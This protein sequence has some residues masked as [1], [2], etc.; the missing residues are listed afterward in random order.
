QPAH[1]AM[2]LVCTD[3]S[4]SEL[5]LVQP[6]LEKPRG[7]PAADLRLA[8]V[9]CIECAEA[10]ESPLVNA[11]REG[12]PVR[13]I[14]DDVDG[15]LSEIPTLDDTEE[16]DERHTP[17]HRQTQSDVVRVLRISAAIPVPEQ[18]VIADGV[19]V[20]ARFT[21]FDSFGGD[22]ERDVAKDLWL[23]DALRTYQR[24]AFSLIDETFKEH[25]VRQCTVVSGK[26][27]LLLEE[28]ECSQSDL[29]VVEHGAAGLF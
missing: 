21:F 9:R 4:L 27:L 16:V 14:A 26:V 23:E 7:V 24:D 29:K 25:L 17:L 18:P 13:V 19:I 3:H 6:L 20:R 28:S 12:Q 22:A 10:G 5:A 2:M 1:G 11:D 8:D 15:P